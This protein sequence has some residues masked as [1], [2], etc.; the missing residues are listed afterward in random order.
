[1]SFPDKDTYDRMIENR[2]F[3]FNSEESEYAPSKGKERCDSCLHYFVR[4]L[5]EFVVC[6]VVRPT[7]DGEESI[8]PN[9]KCKFFTPDGE[10]YPLLE[11]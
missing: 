5:D 1:M 4:K 8:I 3:K 7:E 10:N 11:D 2:P 6:E 9:Y